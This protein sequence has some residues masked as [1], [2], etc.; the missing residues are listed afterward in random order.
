MVKVSFRLSVYMT[1]FSEK[2]PTLFFIYFF[3]C[4]DYCIILSE[5]LPSVASA[6][7]RKWK[8]RIS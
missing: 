8:K 2:T 7:S 1:N 5:K 6:T 4:H 3:C